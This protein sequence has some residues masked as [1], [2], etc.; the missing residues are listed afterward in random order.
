M[1]RVD[2]NETFLI[3]VSVIDEINGIMATGETVYYDLRKQ[4]GD[5]A[6]SPAINGTLTESTTEAGIYS[7]LVS[8]DEAG[9]YIAYATCSGFIV[10]TEE[11]IVNEENIYDLTKQNRHYNLS[12]EDVVRENAI[13]TASQTVRKVAVGN[14]DYIINKIKADS[15][16]NWSSTTVSGLVYAWY[17]NE[18]DDV[19]YRMGGDGL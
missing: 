7:T 16:S 8:I 1:K 17:H 14:T 9:S 11:I 2:I 10:D 19:P 12:V 3:T 15:D 13:A 4:P 18:S 5:V 6:L